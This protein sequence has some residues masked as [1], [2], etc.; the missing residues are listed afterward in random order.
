MS[1]N[2][3]GRDRHR[4][5]DTAAALAGG[6]GEYRQRRQNSVLCAATLGP[7]QVMWCPYISISKH[8]QLVG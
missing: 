7:L 4:H 2:H 8:G 3:K 5:P 1:G 6:P